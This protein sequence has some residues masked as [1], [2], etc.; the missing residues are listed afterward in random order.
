M[1]PGDDDDGDGRTG[2]QTF[3][4]GPL[5]AAGG[6]SRIPKGLLVPLTAR[7]GQAGGGDGYSRT[8]EL[9]AAVDGGRGRQRRTTGDYGRS[10]ADDDGDGGSNEESHILAFNAASPARPAPAVQG[11]G[12]RR[13]HVGS[14]SGATGHGGSGG[15][16]RRGN[17]AA[18]R[19]AQAA[20]CDGGV[21]APPPQKPQ[22]PHNRHKG[23]QQGQGVGNDSPSFPPRL[24][25]QPQPPSQQVAGAGAGAGAGGRGRGGAGAGGA[26][27]TTA[28][29]GL[30][31]GGDMGHSRTGHRWGVC[32]G[33]AVGGT[34]ACGLVQDRNCPA[35]GKLLT[36]RRTIILGPGTCGP[37][38]SHAR[39]H[40]VYACRGAGAGSQGATGGLGA[41]PP[42]THDS[43]DAAAEAAAIAAALA[44]A[45][46][47]A[48]EEEAAEER[49][50]AE[51]EAEARVQ[52]ELAAGMAWV[53]RPGPPI[54]STYQLGRTLGKGSFGVVSQRLRRI[55]W[56]DVCHVVA[57]A[58]RYTVTAAS[59]VPCRWL[60]PPTTELLAMPRSGPRRHPHRQRFG[61]GRQDH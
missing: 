12:G 9:S 58:Y 42:S 23:R 30:G 32:G 44:A 33:R 54:E 31:L 3:L 13:S 38:Y 10:D 45:Q 51:A 34:G 24:G 21:P 7:R 14:D 11:S 55:G 48:A 29:S 59:V 15:S 43:N 28:D 27:R 18:A 40:L 1:V 39:Y 52:A 36:T 22:Q 17:T 56:G 49:A 37:P 60:R 47:A 19:G 25:P 5:L 41:S 2:V 50:R 61:G 46:A 26:R 6:G 4:S 16:G 20:S 57:T 35:R 8:H 53:I